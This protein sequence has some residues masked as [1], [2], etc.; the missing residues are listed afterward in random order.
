M[1]AY[2]KGWLNI[3]V[4][5]IT[6]VGYINMWAYNKL[7]KYTCRHIRQVGEIYMSAYNKLVQYACR[8]Y[9]RL[10]K[11]TCLRIKSC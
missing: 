11:Y 9:N 8:S 6:R 2:K 3:H 5:H 7:V 4:W 10:V 1:P